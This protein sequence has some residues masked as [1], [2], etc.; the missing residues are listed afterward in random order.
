MLLRPSTPVS[1]SRGLVF[2]RPTCAVSPAQPQRI[3]LQQTPRSI[4]PVSSQQQHASGIPPQILSPAVSTSS[5]T[6]LSS[7]TAPSSI[8]SG[9]EQQQDITN[10]PMATLLR[11][12]PIS[13]R[14][15]TDVRSSVTVPRSLRDVATPLGPRARLMTPGSAQAAAAR[16]LARADP[17]SISP[18][19]GHPVKRT[20]TREIE[21]NRSLRGLNLVHPFTLY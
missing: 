15:D 3:I 19:N 7:I 1:G 16:L 21:V 11:N 20:V 17:P 9:F 13:M 4:V 18:S 10:S 5:A 6:L 8:D 12:T 14:F 2:I